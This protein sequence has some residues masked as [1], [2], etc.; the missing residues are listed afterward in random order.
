MSKEISKCQYS[1]AVAKAKNQSY[2]TKP[3]IVQIV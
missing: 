3:Q 2:F 1:S